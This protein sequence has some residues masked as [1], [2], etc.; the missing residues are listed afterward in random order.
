MKRI[1]T[2]EDKAQFELLDKN[3]GIKLSPSEQMGIVHKEGEKVFHIPE[4]KNAQKIPVE[5]RK[6]LHN[7]GLA[8][9]EENFR[10]CDDCSRSY[11]S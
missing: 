2:I 7:M 1:V 10:L 4:C 8:K 11:Y 6:Y 3:A 9:M 5:E